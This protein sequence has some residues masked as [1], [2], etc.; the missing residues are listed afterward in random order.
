MYKSTYGRDWDPRAT[1]GQT[2]CL[3]PASGGIQPLHK[4]TY[5]F[6]SLLTSIMVS[7]RMQQ[8]AA[9]GV[10]AVSALCVC[11][12][13]FVWP[14]VF[15]CMYV[16]YA[17][18]CFCVCA[19]WYMFSLVTHQTWSYELWQPWQNLWG[20]GFGLPL[21][22]SFDVIEKYSSDK[23]EEKAR[24]LFLPLSM[25][26]EH[27]WKKQLCNPNTMVGKSTEKLFTQRSV[28]YMHLR[29]YRRILYS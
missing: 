28:C 10:A 11:L 23:N 22:I 26:Q 20:T 21:L 29:F 18:V 9:D 17:Y 12:W 2:G 27:M 4:S 25:L 1:T 8:D 24:F 16:V 7:K 5:T 14:A 6:C 19:H 3:S 13:W 15:T